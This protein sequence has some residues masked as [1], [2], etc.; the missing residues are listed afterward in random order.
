[1][2]SLRALACRFGHRIVIVAVPSRHI[3]VRTRRVI[4]SIALPFGHILGSIRA[5]YRF[6]S[7]IDSGA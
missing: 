3:I 4:V 6:R 1:M 2:V 5:H 7:G